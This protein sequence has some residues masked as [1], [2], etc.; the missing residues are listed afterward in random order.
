MTHDH[1]IVELLR[2]EG[3]KLE[4]IQGAVDKLP[5]DD[6]HRRPLLQFLY[7]RASNISLAMHAMRSNDYYAAG[8]A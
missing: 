5:A 7:R 1:D 2:L 3:A 4:R 8:N 6:P